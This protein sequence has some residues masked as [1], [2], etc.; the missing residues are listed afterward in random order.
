MGE[1]TVLIYVRLSGP[2]PLHDRNWAV[3]TGRRCYS[4]CNDIRTDPCLS[5]ASIPSEAPMEDL[6]CQMTI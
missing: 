2:I 1:K 6:P 3:R 5:Y 4:S